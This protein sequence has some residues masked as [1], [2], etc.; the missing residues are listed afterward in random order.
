MPHAETADTWDRYLKKISYPSSALRHGPVFSN[1]DPTLRAAISGMG[2]ALTR[3]SYDAEFLSAG[4]LRKLPF[5]K[6]DPEFNNV[7]V[8]RTVSY[9]KSPFENLSTGF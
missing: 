6:V 5:P 2:I 7:L 9:K 3:S 8:C 1:A 4:A